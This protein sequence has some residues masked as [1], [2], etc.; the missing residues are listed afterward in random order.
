MESATFLLRVRVG[1][2]DFSIL[3]DG[4]VGNG[5]VDLNE[6]LEHN[7]SSTD[8]EVTYLAVTHLAIGQTYIL[9]TGEQFAVGIVGVQTVEKRRRGLK[10]NVA[11]VVVTNAPAVENHQ[12]SFFCHNDILY[13]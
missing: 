9:S 7:T 11:F 6:I 13:F 3:H 5:A 2:N 1:A 12:K 4:I 8:I 10:N